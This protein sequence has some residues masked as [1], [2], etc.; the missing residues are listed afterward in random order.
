M[1]VNPFKI[2]PIPGPKTVTLKT[3][4]LIDACFLDPETGSVIEDSTGENSVLMS[5]LLETLP[6]E[7]L[8]VFV[9]RNAV[10]MVRLLKGLADG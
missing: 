4:Y 3:D 2:T 1:D 7:A 9:D 10:E 8:A 6:S 5:T